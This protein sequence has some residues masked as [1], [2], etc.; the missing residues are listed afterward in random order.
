MPDAAPCAVR[1]ASTSLLAAPL[2]HQLVL[3]LGFPQQFVVDTYYTAALEKSSHLHILLHT[4]AGTPEYL[5]PE[6]VLGKSYGKATDMWSLGV[7]YLFLYL[8]KC[9]QP[10]CSSPFNNMF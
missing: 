6:I 4:L 10:S 9:T 8:V 7:S 2:I 1:I 3:L 5:S